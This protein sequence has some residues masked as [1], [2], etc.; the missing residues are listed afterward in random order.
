MRFSA[1]L[2]SLV[3]VIAFSATAFAA[4]SQ[5]KMGTAK[6]TV[7][8]NP[9]G[10]FIA[11]SNQVKGVA[12]KAGAGFVAKKVYL[13]LN[14]LKTGIELRDHHMN[15]NYFESKKYP[16][17]ILDQAQGKD[18]K[19]TGTLKIRNLPKPIS[20]TYTVNGSTLEAKFKSKLSDF[21]IKKANYMGVGVE[22]E[23]EVVVT[24]P[25]Q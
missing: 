20:G 4:P 6:Y 7:E 24:L 22:D 11:E 16:W 5:A 17:A 23:V 13:N 15:E 10:S 18:G 1:K 21:R 2:F 12:T 14:T 8:L 9:T 25:I 19:F 3:S